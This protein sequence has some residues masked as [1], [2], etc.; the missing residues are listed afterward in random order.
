MSGSINED[1]NDRWKKLYQYL[2]IERLEFLKHGVSQY[3]ESLKV[4]KVIRDRLDKKP[5]GDKD[6]WSEE[7]D[8]ANIADSTE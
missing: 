5:L 3:K 7:P 4:M 6:F 1:P 8:L 2:I